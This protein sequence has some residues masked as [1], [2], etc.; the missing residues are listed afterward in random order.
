MKSFKVTATVKGIEVT[1]TVNAFTAEDAR[2]KARKDLG[3]EMRGIFFP[4]HWS[5]ILGCE[6][7]KQ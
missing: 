5:E 4:L 1:A 7:I 2:Q 6:E 3:Y